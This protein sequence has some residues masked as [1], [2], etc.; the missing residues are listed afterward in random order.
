MPR[1]IAG[2]ARGRRLVS[3]RGAET[4]PTGDRVKQTLFDV[5]A[6]RIAGCR[7]LDPFAGGGGIGLEALSRG[8]A[9]AVLVERSPA[10]VA[11]L[12]RN[13]ALLAGAG[14]ELQVFQQDARIALAALA[15]R[16]ARF[17]V[18]YLDP[19]YQSDLYEPVLEQL[20]ETGLLEPD[21]VVVVEHFHKRVLPET[22]GGLVQSRSLKV[23]D[24][25]LTFYR[26]ER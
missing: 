24:H 19:P 7:F 17:D 15:D 18:V 14:G 5:L 6:P 9:R 8:A 1:I 4:R 23:G 3:P 20:G 2:H 11:A 13:Q 10:A 26:R 22:I 16:G 25:R 12:R 21:G